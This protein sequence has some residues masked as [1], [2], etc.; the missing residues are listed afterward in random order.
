[1]LEDLGTVSVLFIVENGHVGKVKLNSEQRD[2]CCMPRCT[3]CRCQIVHRESVSRLC[4]HSFAPAQVRSRPTWQVQHDRSPLSLYDWIC[5]DMH[6]TLL[7]EAVHPREATWHK[8]CNKAVYQVRSRPEPWSRIILWFLQVHLLMTS[9]TSS[10]GQTLWICLMACTLVVS[11]MELW[12]DVDQA[13]KRSFSIKASTL[14]R[15]RL[16]RIK[17]PISIGWP[18]TRAASNFPIGHFSRRL[19]VCR[20]LKYET[21]VQ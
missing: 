13:S 17:N 2:A 14:L 10:R 16:C 6:T 3:A 5:L 12:V 4:T 20:Y 21:T 19:W 9:D 11:L 8:F 1:M 15:R 7:H 18:R